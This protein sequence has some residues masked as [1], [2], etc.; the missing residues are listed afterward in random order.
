MSRIAKY[1]VPLPSGVEAQLSGEKIVIKGPLGS[2]AQPLTGEVAIAQESG[3]LTFKVADESRHAKAMSG[4]LR[5]LVANMVQGV[6]KGFEKRLS[7]VGVGYKAAAQGK[8]LNLS[9]G[10]SHPVDYALPE[11]IK[12][13][14]PTPTEIIIKGIDKQRVGQVAA[15]VR[16]FRP[17]EPYKGK[18]VRYVDEVV[19]IKET[20]KK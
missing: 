19:I 13:E 17:P 8:T 11:G 7:L 14:T 12:A 4:T 10:F 15:E 6:S 18:G 5:A 16:A 1:P 3:A 2:L 9:L 20:K